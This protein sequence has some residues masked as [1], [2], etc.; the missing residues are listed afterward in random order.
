MGGL[1]LEVVKMSLYIFFPVAI[2]VYFNVPAFQEKDM[3]GWR[4]RFENTQKLPK[5]FEETKALAE[6]FLAN[7]K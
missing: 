6:E 3:K 7:K 1:G 5:T 2:F 4:K